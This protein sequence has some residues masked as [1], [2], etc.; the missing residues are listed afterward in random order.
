MALRC[1]FSPFFTTHG[2]NNN[3]IL[4]KF[5]FQIDLGARAVRSLPRNGFNASATGVN[6]SIGGEKSGNYEGNREIKVEKKNA[7]VRFVRETR[8]ESL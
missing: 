5:V 4:K 8:K 1:G 3:A 7:S 6:Q 2:K